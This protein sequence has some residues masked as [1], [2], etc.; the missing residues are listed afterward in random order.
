[1]ELWLLASSIL[2]VVVAENY[3]L[4]TSSTARG[5]VTKLNE[6]LT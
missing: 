5:T 6:N 2:T 3:N 1:M 4:G